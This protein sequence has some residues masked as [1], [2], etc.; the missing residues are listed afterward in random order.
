MCSFAPVFPTLLSVPHP[1]PL[2]LLCICSHFWSP[3]TCCW[4]SIQKGKIELSAFLI[5]RQLKCGNTLSKKVPF[6]TGTAFKSHMGIAQW[7]HVNAG[8]KHS[9]PT[10]HYLSLKL[11]TVTC[12]EAGRSSKKQHI[13]RKWTEKTPTMIKYVS[14][15]KK[16]KSQTKSKHPTKQQ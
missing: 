12:L 15:G 7:N 13:Y 1:P 14:L 2:Y 11:V 4:H 16:N 5:F 10:L 3:I 6:Y 9:W 8:S